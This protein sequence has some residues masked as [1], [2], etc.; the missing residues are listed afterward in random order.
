P[1]DGQ[2]MA[3]DATTDRR[4]Y[5]AEWLANGKNNY[6]VRSIVNRVWRHYMG[7]GLIEPVD[8]LRATNPA[9]NEPLMDALCKDL[10]QHHFDLKYLMRQVMNSRTYQLTSRPL[11]ENK[12]DDRQYSRYFVRRL[13]AE[14]LLDAICQVTGQNEKFPGLPAGYR[15]IELPDTGV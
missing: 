3:T 1:Y 15:A 11:P 4:V 13:T 12:K 14:Q 9:S 8:D 2:P 10:A 6:F 7:R 5:L